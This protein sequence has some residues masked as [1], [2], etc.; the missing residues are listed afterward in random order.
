MLR[1]EKIRRRHLISYRAKLG[2]PAFL[3][4]YQRIEAAAQH[5]PHPLRF[6]FVL[7]QMLRGLSNRHS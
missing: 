1:L 6:H 5:S 2:N 4:G 3:D 7:L